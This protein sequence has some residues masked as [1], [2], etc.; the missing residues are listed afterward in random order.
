MCVCVYCAEMRL[1][2]AFFNQM[3]SFSIDLV[4]TILIIFLLSGQTSSDLV[5][6]EWKCYYKLNAKQ[7]QPTIIIGA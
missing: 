3:L 1:V 2:V 5:I 4:L 7:V 6:S